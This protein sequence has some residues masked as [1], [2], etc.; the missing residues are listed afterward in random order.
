MKYEIDKNYELTF[1]NEVSWIATIWTALDELPQ[2]YT[3]SDQWDEV[4]TAMAWIQQRL[5]VENHTD[6]HPLVDM[7]SLPD[8]KVCGLIHLDDVECDQELIVCP[9]CNEDMDAHD[10]RGGDACPEKDGELMLDKSK[11]FGAEFEGKYVQY[12]IYATG[13]N[14]D[15]IV[16]WDEDGYEGPKFYVKT[17][18]TW[19]DHMENIGT[20]SEVPVDGVDHMEVKDFADIANAFTLKPWWGKDGE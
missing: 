10:L 1:N 2:E 20:A 12:N 17:I 15:G 4:T 6:V 18:G 11:Y 9:D 5:G 14:I 13:I 8:C 3:E 19:R 16:Y 7:Y